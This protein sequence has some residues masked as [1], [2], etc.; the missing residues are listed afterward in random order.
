M[1]HRSLNTCIAHEGRGVVS[2]HCWNLPTSL[3][4]LVEPLPNHSFI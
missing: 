1:R 3:V 4:I 2:G